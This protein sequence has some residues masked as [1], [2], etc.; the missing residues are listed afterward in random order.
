[1]PRVYLSASTQE[2]NLCAMGDTE[3]QHMNK[4]A[5]VVETLLA[6]QP[7]F[8]VFRNRPE[9]TLQETVKESNSLGVGAHVALHSNAGGSKGTECF[10]WP[11]SEPSRK[12]GQ[13]LYDGVNRLNPNP[14]RGVKDGSHLYE[15]NSTTAPAALIEVAFHD[16][17]QEARW[18]HDNIQQI[19][20]AVAQAVCT[21]FGVTMQVLPPATSP[22]KLVIDGKEIDGGAIV[23]DGKAYAWTRGLGEALG[24]VVE[25]DAKTKT[26]SITKPGKPPPVALPKLEQ[27]DNCDIITAKPEQL[28]VDLCKGVLDK[29]GINASYL[30]GNLNPLGVVIVGGKVIADRVAHRPARP[31]F[32]IRLDGKADILPAVE[33]AKDIQCARCA[34]GAGPLLLPSVSTQGEFPADITQGSRERS[35]VGI[36]PDGQVKLVTTKPMTLPQLSELMKG[37]GCSQALNLDGGGSVSMRYQGDI[38]QGCSRAISTA[39]I[40]REA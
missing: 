26:V 11:K 17:E 25:W 18:I 6:A 27:R 20:A 34:V 15:I 37:L 36:T 1:M 39:I 19:G 40:L 9:M 2:K 31:V 32:I 33:A 14:G 28:A 16:N 7:G 5:D 22:A 8:V 38:I 13:L 30:D 29:D 23:I 3:E 35:A 21:Y 4:I 10:C 12:L 24:C